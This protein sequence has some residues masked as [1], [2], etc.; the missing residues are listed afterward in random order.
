MEILIAVIIGLILTAIFAAG[1]RGTRGWDGLLLFFA[2]I[3]LATWAGGLWIIP[4]GPLLA[5]IAWVP[6]VFIGILFA[7]LLAA[8]IPPSWS[9]RE[10]YSD[11]R[12]ESSSTTAMWGLSLF[13]WLL[14]LVLVVSVVLGYIA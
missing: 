3:F 12:T 4:A 1:F 13:F 5:G 10:Y 14:L 2:I 11:V 8:L 6:L 9:P 7:L